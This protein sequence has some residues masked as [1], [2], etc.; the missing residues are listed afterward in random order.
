MSEKIMIIRKDI[1]QSHITK[2]KIESLTVIYFYFFLTFT[3][4]AIESSI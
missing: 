4:E 3:T 2:L 1:L